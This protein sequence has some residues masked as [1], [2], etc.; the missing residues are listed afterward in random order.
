MEP[1]GIAGCGRMGAGM[2]RNLLAAGIDARGLDLRPPGD[3]PDLPV[4]DDVDAFAG[5]LGTTFVVVRDAAQIDALLFGPQALLER[6]GALRRL[7]ISSTVSPRYVA[8]LADRLPGGLALVDAPMSGAQSGAEAGT[9]T[10]MLGG[11]DA[12]L[13]ALM[14]AFAAMGEAIHRMGPS[15]AG[16]AAK[17]LNNMM[18]AASMVST[19][20]A[21]DWCGEWGLDRDR[22]LAMADSAS[23]RNWFT[24]LWDR[25]EFAGAGFDPDNSVGIVAKDV[26]CAADAAPAGAATD[27]PAL[28]AAKLRGLKPL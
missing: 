5:G 15:P 17:V 9:L 19:R 24:A 11:D 28:L 7:V 27:F 26:L 3:F 10:F 25:I 20:L 13:D 1:I 4:T 2:L 8:A 12:D 23:G 6:A 22:F 21:L 14:P 18:A 16:H